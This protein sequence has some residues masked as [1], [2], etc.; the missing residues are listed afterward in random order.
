MTYKKPKHKNTKLKTKLKNLNDVQ[1]K[2]KHKNTKLKTKTQKM[3]IQQ[4]TN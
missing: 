2:P 4:M 3:T 1:K